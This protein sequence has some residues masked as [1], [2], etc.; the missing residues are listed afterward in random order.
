MATTEELIAQLQAETE[1]KYIV[2]DPITRE[3]TVP[4]SESIFGVYQDNDTERKY[5]RCPRMIDN[6]V[7]LSTCYLYI[8]YI[9]SGGNYGQYL[10][11]DVTVEGDDIVFS[12]ILSSKVFDV[13]KDSTIRFAVQAKKLNLEN[14]AT[15]VFVTRTATGMSY[16]TIDADEQISV[17]YVDIILELLSRMDNLEFLANKQRTIFLPAANWTG[18]DALYSQTVTIDGITANSRI[19]LQPT[20]EQLRSLLTSEITMVAENDGGVVTVYAIGD[21]P[22]VDYTMQVLITEVRNTE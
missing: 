16:E 2:V 19:D 5:F 22:T 1:D 21:I 12:W 8:N 10:C 4:I 17:Q 7:D 20:P 6:D 3:L 13:N 14:K 9:S 18:N 15:N 11:E